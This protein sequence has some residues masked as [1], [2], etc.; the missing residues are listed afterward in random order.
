MLARSLELSLEDSLFIWLIDQ[1]TYSPHSNDVQVTWDLALGA[2]AAPVMYYNLRFKDQ[3]GGTM[4]VG[5]NDLFTQPW[6]TVGGS[7][8]V[9]DSSVMSAPRQISSGIITCVG[10][11]ADPY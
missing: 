8:W 2:E 4:K 11:D 7:N 5:T 1:Q 9:W 10:Y 6:N 3:E